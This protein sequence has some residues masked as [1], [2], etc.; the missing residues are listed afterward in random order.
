MKTDKLYFKLPSDLSDGRQV[1]RLQDK[2]PTRGLTYR[3]CHV[4]KKQ[5]TQNK[6]VFYVFPTEI[7]KVVVEAL[8]LS[9]SF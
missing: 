9:S 1:A 3:H 8:L 4:V 7:V 5:P 2:S 6:V